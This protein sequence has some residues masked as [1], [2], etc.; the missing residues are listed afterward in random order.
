MSQL[1][2]ANISS[3]EV[4]FAAENVAIRCTHPVPFGCLGKSC[5]M[6]AKGPFSF[7]QFLVGSVLTST[8]YPHVLFHTYRRHAA[9][10]ACTY[11][12]SK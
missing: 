4:D 9:T 7:L 12:I 1:E 2:T 11:R 6:I 8:V 10:L 3:L 5:G